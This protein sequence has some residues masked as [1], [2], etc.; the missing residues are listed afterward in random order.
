MY[1]PSLEEMEAFGYVGIND[2]DVYS[3]NVDSFMVNA[4]QEDFATKPYLQLLGAAEIA[5]HIPE[6]FGYNVPDY[7]NC[8]D[9][10]VYWHEREEFSPPYQVIIRNI[11]NDCDRTRKGKDCNCNHVHNKAYNFHTA[12]D[13]KS[14]MFRLVLCWLKQESEK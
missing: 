11:V 4:K 1:E 7:Y 10:Q 6:F 5:Y 8:D 12:E 9:K 2:N 3:E 13:A 14:F